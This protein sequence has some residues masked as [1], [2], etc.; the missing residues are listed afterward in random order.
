M[1]R[2]SED[3]RVNDASGGHEW[4]APGGPGEPSVGAVPDAPLA[5]P[6]AP[7]SA[8]ASYAPPA[9]TVVTAAAPAYVAPTF[10]SWQPG[11]IPLR[12][13]SFGEFLSV[14][15]KAM[16]YNR[17]V[18]IGGPLLCVGAAMVLLAAALWLAVTDPSLALTS[19]TAQLQG[20]QASTVV[21][22]IVAFLALILAD[23]A[24]SAVV[25][26]GVSRAVLGERI[27]VGEAFKALG[28]RVGQLLL[29]W[30]ISSVVVLLAMVPGGIAM[31]IGA[32][33]GDDTTI[34]LG[35]FA[36]FALGVVVALPVYLIGAVA[37]C[38][39][40]LEQKGAI[41]SIRRTIGVIR[42]RFWWTVLIVIVTGLLVGIITGIFQQV[43][44]LVGSIAFAVGMSGAWV[45]TAIF[46]LVLV[47]GSVITYVLTYSYMGCVYVLVYIDARIRH[48]GFDL[49]LARAA[50]SRRR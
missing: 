44:T 10:R 39:I 47:L 48:E 32:Q 49:D 34:A 42:G 26:P 1:G 13:V 22:A 33:S 4:T 31:V 35:L 29:L 9:P 18:V 3:G 15:F 7:G 23:A 28:P 19:P 41:A 25:A 50:E 21:V 14:P 20:I 24:A 38:V 40:V 8:P 5:S 6:P 45:G 16:R 12:P 37:R 11:I 17:A 36:M 2:D 30:L 27:T 43:L 46:I